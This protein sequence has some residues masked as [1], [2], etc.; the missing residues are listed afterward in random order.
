M[1][2]TNENEQECLMSPWLLAHPTSDLCLK[3]PYGGRVATWR[4][5]NIARLTQAAAN[6]TQKETLVISI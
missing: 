5:I 1:F 4:S 6:Q 2:A 3:E